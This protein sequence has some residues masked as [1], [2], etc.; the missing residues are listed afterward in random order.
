MVDQGVQ[1]KDGV[2]RIA[3]SQNLVDFQQVEF[4]GASGTLRATGRVRLDGAE[5]DLT[6]SIVA[7]KLELFA[8]PDRNLS[9]SGSASVANAR[10]G[11]RHG[12]QRQIRGR[13]RVV[14]S[15]GAGRAEASATT[16]W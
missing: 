12:D 14:R 9:L 4:H 6:A 13:S 1:L 2:V 5:P 7:D 15:A 11:G 3:L 8:A 16:S 10:R